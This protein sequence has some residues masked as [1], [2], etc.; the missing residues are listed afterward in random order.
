VL[1]LQDGEIK[2][3]ETNGETGKYIALSHRWG[4]T[5]R[6]LTTNA[7]FLSMKQGFRLDEKVREY[8]PTTFRDAILATAALGIRYLWIDS[9]CIIRE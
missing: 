7:I 2:F 8:V 9:L 1:D 6:F 4:V 3:M 5:R